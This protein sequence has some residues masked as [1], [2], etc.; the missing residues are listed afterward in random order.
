MGTMPLAN[1]VEL[2]VK[3]GDVRRLEFVESPAAGGGEL[4]PGELLVR[5]E[6]FGLSA[7]NVTYVVTGRSLQYFAFFPA[8]Q[9]GWGKI[10]VWGM[11]G[12]VDSRHP[13]LVTGTRLYGFL[14]L[15]RYIRLSPA[16]R[17]AAGFDV[18]RG[19][20]PAVYNQYALVGADPFHLPAREDHMLL[21]RPLFFTDF[22]LDDYLVD[23]HG[24]FGAD[25]LVISSASSKTSVGLAFM[26]ARRRRTGA[27]GASLQVVGLT[28]AHH[29]P[30]VEGLHVYDRV[31]RYEDMGALPRSVP[32]VVVDVAGNTATLEAL[33][34]HFG[35][36]LKASV[37]VG[38]SHWHR[39][40]AAAAD[41]L[42]A[43]PAGTHYFFAP[44]E[45]EKRL[46]EW[47]PA[48]TVEKVAAA[49]QEFMD[50]VDTRCRLVYAAGQGAVAAA[51]RTLLAGAQPPDQGSLLSLWDDA[52]V[53][54][55]GD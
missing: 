10:P 35:A 24:C 49:W 2:L 54:H 17:T 11:G 16:R 48:R 4:R 51:Y 13:D 28:A 7:N 36:N 15:A 21:F 8:A 37:L 42:P 27:A 12:I 29:V 47:G 52:F 32:A 31:L 45:V 43:P 26:L 18:D 19:A 33:R 40:A 39:S 55:P 46:R 50:G 1:N 44:A 30:F 38:M 41:S 53:T 6:K 22:F 20:L 23:G 3:E 14:P 34:A 9:A 25:A 5:V